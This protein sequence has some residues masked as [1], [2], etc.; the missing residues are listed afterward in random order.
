MTDTLPNSVN[1]TCDET[2]VIA[3][4][5]NKINKSVAEPSVVMAKPVTGNAM[6]QQNLELVTHVCGES[7]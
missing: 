4:E 5:Q 3:C 7:H 6:K 1:K 2:V